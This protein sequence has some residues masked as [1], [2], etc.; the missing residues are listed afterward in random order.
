MSPERLRS[1]VLLLQERLDVTRGEATLFADESREVLDRAERRGM[2]PGEAVD[3]ALARR[4]EVEYELGR[5]E[6]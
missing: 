2:T 1:V 6:N 4:P 5:D 3:W